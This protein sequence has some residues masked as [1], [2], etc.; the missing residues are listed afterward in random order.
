MV[1][2]AGGLPIS[3]GLRPANSGSDAGVRPYGSHPRPGDTSPAEGRVLPGT[4]LPERVRLRRASPYIVRQPMLMQRVASMAR[5]RATETEADDLPRYFV[6]VRGL[7][8][9]EP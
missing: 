6:W 1:T 5:R 4:S 2:P 7:E 3:T 8:G 9:P